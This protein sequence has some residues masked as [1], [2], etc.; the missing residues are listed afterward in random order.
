[1]KGLKHPAT[2]LAAL[3]LFVALGG[4]AAWASG[5]ISGSSIK[6]HSIAEKKLTNKAIKALHGQRGPRGPRGATGATGA[7]GAAGAQG[8]PGPA[9]PSNTVRWNDSAAVRDVVGTSSGPDLSNLSDRTG[10]VTLATVGT[11]K[12]DGI[13]WD[14]G[15]NTFAA[16]FIETTQDGARTQGYSGEGMTPLNVADGP[17]EISEDIAKNTSASNS[18]FGPDDGSWAAENAAGTLV[19]DGFGNQAVPN[20]SGG[21][22]AQCAFSG[23]LVEIAGS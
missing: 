12:V 16:T 21:A 9:G 2:I 23:Y 19:F 10:I 1:V 8:P 15:T 4:G 17:V 14:D 22:N 6:N 11:L 3:A 13:C 7:A 18:F 5:L 20:L